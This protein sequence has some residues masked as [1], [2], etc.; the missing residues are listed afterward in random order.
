MI[1]E[2]LSIKIATMS[3]FCALMVVG[4]HMAGS[5]TVGV[6]SWWLES[7]FGYG[8]FAI[9]VP[10]FFIVSG[11]FVELAYVRGVAYKTIVAKRLRTILI[12]FLIWNL[13]ALV[14]NIG[15]ISVN[16]W[17]H[18]RPW[19]ANIQNMGWHWLSVVGVYPFSG[20]YLGPLWYLRGL[21]LLVLLSPVLRR[22]SKIGLLILFVVMYVTMSI[23]PEKSRAY[24]FFRWTIPTLGLFYFTLGMYLVQHPIP[25]RVGFPLAC[26]AFPLGLGVLICEVYCKYVGIPPPIY[27][28]ALMIPLAL[29]FVWYLVPSG[30][31]RLK[32]AGYTFPIYVLHYIF[33]SLAFFVSHSTSLQW[34]FIR[35]LV[36]V[37]GPIGVALVLRRF[38]PRAAWIAFGGR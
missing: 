31:G 12:P 29:G 20:P 19:G 7:I 28:R 2:S 22:L 26:W 37:L 16:D 32:L 6:A 33:I 1:S 21:F 15:V 14:V 13:A 9:A 36:G 27:F 18:S 34:Y 30:I 35:G 3:F 23:F 25:R 17:V 24:H 5:E 8:L 10:F 4:V 11:Y 38:W